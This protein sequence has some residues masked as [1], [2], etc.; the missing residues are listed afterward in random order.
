MDISARFHVGIYN[1]QKF[2]YL[3]AGDCDRLQRLHN[4]IMKIT[5]ELSLV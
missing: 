5:G 2:F 4:S 3:C 1:R